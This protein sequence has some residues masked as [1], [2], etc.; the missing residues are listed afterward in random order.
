[1]TPILVNYLFLLAL[2]IGFVAGLRSMLAPA[3]VAWAA[4]LG[5][6]NLADTRL[7]F[8]GSTITVAV[9]SLLALGE[10]IADKLPW[11]PRRTTI[12]PLIT[13]MITGGLCG[14][15]FFVAAGRS[16]PLGALLGALGGVL[17]GY[18]GYETRR[19]LVQDWHLKDFLVAL[20]EDAV[21]L[22]LALFLV[23]R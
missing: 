10:L 12:G 8:L 14:A 17:G 18:A 20:V 4:H 3:A 1:R 19:R 5:W 16:L 9:F 6:L 11:I 2:G 23:S 15:S 7:A 22:G 21:A 13:R